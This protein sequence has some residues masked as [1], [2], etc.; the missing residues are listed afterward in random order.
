MW[1]EYSW[2]PFFLCLKV[3]S[4]GFYCGW[5]SAVLD[6]KTDRWSNNSRPDITTSSTIPSFFLSSFRPWKEP[7]KKR[8]NP[9]QRSS[10]FAHN[11]NSIQ[12][13]LTKSDHQT[14]EPAWEAAPWVQDV[15]KKKERKKIEETNHL[16]RKCFFFLTYYRDQRTLFI[17]ASQKTCWTGYYTHARLHAVTTYIASTYRRI[18]ASL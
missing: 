5:N 6:R 3:V 15:W 11:P 14:W 16:G 18:T 13:C 17:S 10:Q 1:G 12:L 9:L 4:F 2:S 7:R 8:S